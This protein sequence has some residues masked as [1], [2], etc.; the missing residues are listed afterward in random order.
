[1]EIDAPPLPPPPPPQQ[2]QRTVAMED[3][4]SPMVNLSM[5][6]ETATGLSVVI[7]RMQKEHAAERLLWRKDVEDIRAMYEFHTR[8]LEDH[9]QQLLMER[10][11]REKLLMSELEEMKHRLARSDERVDAVIQ[12]YL[13]SVVKPLS[14]PSRAPRASSAGPAVSRPETPSAPT[15]LKPLSVASFVPPPLF[16]P[17]PKDSANTAPTTP[18]NPP[19]PPVSSSSTDPS[20]SKQS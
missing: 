1:M 16:G 12:T 10:D 6:T 5:P 18:L 14:S 11:S 3:L 7:E 8:E 4:D 13:A 20:S 2:Q 15:I 17:I 19:R 9:H